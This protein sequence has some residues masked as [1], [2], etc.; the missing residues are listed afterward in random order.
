MAYRPRPRNI[1]AGGYGLGQMKKNA[2]MKNGKTMGIS[3]SVVDLSLVG[4]GLLL[5]LVTFPYRDAPIGQTLLVAGGGLAAVGLAFLIRDLLMS[6][7][8][9]R[10][11]AG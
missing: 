11:I 7:Q 8:V 9:S 5:G 3:P 1:L 2:E 10:A 6:K 4:S